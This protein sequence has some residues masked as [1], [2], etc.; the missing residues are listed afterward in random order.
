MGCLS[1]IR[2]LEGN[3]GNVRKVS[4]FSLTFL[5][6]NSYYHSHHMQVCDFLSYIPWLQSSFL[7]AMP[8]CLQT[9]NHP[10]YSVHPAGKFTLFELL[11]QLKKKKKKEIMMV[12]VATNI[13]ASWL[14]K[15]EPTGASTTRANYP[16]KQN[17]LTQFILDCTSLNLEKRILL[18]EYEEVCPLLFNLSRDLCYNIMKKR[19]NEVKL[20]K[21]RKNT[22]LFSEGYNQRCLAL[23]GGFL[24]CAHGYASWEHRFIINLNG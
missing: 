10:A 2:K 24:M 9:N 20:L 3:V 7:Q 18:S 14:P 11:A 19:N 23:P 5:K 8:A 15:R 17:Q 21:V 4:Y 16:R 12:F 22:L 6:F 13:I 1:P